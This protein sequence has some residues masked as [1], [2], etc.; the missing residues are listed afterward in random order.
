MLFQEPEVFITVCS[1][2]GV[3]KYGKHARNLD[4]RL[5]LNWNN[6]DDPQPGDVVALFDC[7]PENKE[8]RSS[9]KKGISIFDLARETAAVES[10]RGYHRTSVRFERK[11]LTT[12]GDTCLG[13]WIAYLRRSHTSSSWLV[14]KS[15]QFRIRPHWMRELRNVIGDI[16]LTSLMIP[17]THDAGAW[18]E[19][20][21]V[22]CENIYVRYYIW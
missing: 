22:R 8:I 5:E 16:P 11:P 2:A 6:F 10:S 13:W 9:N 12:K 15:N 3:A 7:D 14:L 20:E 17:G 1:M 4:R 18:M 21:P 19:Y